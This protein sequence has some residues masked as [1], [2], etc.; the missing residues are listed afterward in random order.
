MAAAAASVRAYA[1]A[2]SR[3][4]SARSAAGTSAAAAAA[5]AMGF[6][7][8]CADARALSVGYHSSGAAASLWEDFVFSTCQAA[9]EAS[10]VHIPSN[11]QYDV[12]C[13]TCPIGNSRLDTAQ[14][15]CLQHRLHL[16]QLG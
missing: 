8:G 5:A 10:N 12:G 16:L 6:P 2:L 3:G 11:K 15:I 1:C 13:G 14:Q 4:K 9:E 7:S